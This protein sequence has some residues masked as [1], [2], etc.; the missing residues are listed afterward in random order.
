MDVHPPKNGMYRYWSIAM[1]VPFLWGE[2]LWD[3][4]GSCKSYGMMGQWQTTKVRL[5]QTPLAIL[6][7]ALQRLLPGPPAWNDRN[8]L[9]PGETVGIAMSNGI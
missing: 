1:L 3:R 2:L 4:P 9:C 5:P 6:A 8:T 7:P